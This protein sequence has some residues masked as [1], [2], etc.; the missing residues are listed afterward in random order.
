MITL[1]AFLFAITVL[2][3][4][5]EYGHYRVAVA[6]GV[7]VTRFSIGFGKV[8]LR[9]RP[10][11][12]RAGQD[13][14]FVFCL[15]P[16]G[17]YVK[18]LDE[19]EDSVSEQDRPYA[20][21]RQSLLKRSAIVVAGPA[22]NFLLALA[23]YACLAWV[24]VEKPR[25]IMASPEPGS[26]A[27]QAGVRAGDRY[28]GI[29][30]MVAL[31]E[32]ITEAS[33]DGQTS[34]QLVSENGGRHIQLPLAQGGALEPDTDPLQ[35]LGLRGVLLEP[36]IGEVQPNSAAQKAGL[37]AGDRV[38]SLAGQPVQDAAELRGM[39]RRQTQIQDWLIERSGHNITLS[40]EPKIVA[41]PHNPQQRIGQIGAYLGGQPQTFTERHTGFAA[42]QEALRETAKASSM[43]LRMLFKMLTG[44]AS[45]KNISGP[46]TIAD[47]AGKTAEISW[48]AYLSFLAVISLSLGVMNLLPLPM[49]DGGHL[50]YYL[51][52]AVRGKPLSTRAQNYLQR[53][54]LASLGLL[55][56]I[57]VFNDLVRF[58]K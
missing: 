17:G 20:F 38:L 25:A 51:W 45:L 49:L 22:A 15:I 23:C 57:A 32:K 7:K 24:G 48:R 14:E 11:R 50:M 3:S 56:G 29:P 47:Y 46:L 35:S 39:I 43:T 2:V 6:C 16:L 30:S 40:V 52:E 10:R 58:L 28:I 19:N 41:D 34:I 21:N 36:I 9:Y 26:I 5:H 37:Q 42:L 4:V 54:G 53:F 31:Q 1:L 33:L 44:Q 8:L 27:E 12:Q 13:T 55:M 18:M